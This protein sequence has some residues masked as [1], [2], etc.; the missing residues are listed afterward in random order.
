MKNEGVW[1]AIHAEL[2]TA[3]CQQRALDSLEQDFNQEFDAE[4]NLLDE[5]AA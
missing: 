5:Q 1:A 2:E 4:E 3:E